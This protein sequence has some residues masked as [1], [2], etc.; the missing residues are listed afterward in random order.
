M[1]DNLNDYERMDVIKKNE[2]KKYLLISFSGLPFVFIGHY[3]NMYNIFGAGFLLFIGLALGI[4]GMIFYYINF[5]K[6]ISWKAEVK[7]KEK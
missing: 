1:S 7:S 2:L 6:Y 5:M 3:L 4:V